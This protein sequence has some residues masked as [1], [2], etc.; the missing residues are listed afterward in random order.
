M[1]SFS[2]V[3]QENN[4]SRN[5]QGEVEKVDVESSDQADYSDKCSENVKSE[6]E[7]VISGTESD[8]KVVSRDVYER[9]LQ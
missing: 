8:S 7:F 3:E 9:F 5:S 2:F 6:G 4:N 1:I